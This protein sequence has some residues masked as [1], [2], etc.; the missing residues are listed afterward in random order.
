MRRILQLT[1]TLVVAFLLFHDI[2]SAESALIG[3]IRY[4]ID[5][6]NKT[7]AVTQPWYPDEDYI[8]TAIIPEKI[9]YKGEEYIVNALK[10]RAFYNC[11][12][13][14][15]VVVP[16]TIE[17]VGYQCFRYCEKLTDV[18]LPDNLP[19]LSESMFSECVSLEEI[20]LPSHITEIP[21]F[22]FSNCSGLKS[23]VIPEGVEKVCSQAFAYADRLI[24]ITLP[25]SLKEWDSN[26]AARY[27]TKVYI[28]NID[29]FAK[30]QCFEFLPRMY[31]L[32]KDNNEVKE[33]QLPI[34]V[35]DT[36]M[37]ENCGSIVSIALS[38]TV[39]S[40]SFSDANE[41]LEVISINSTIRNVDIGGLENLKTVNCY[42]P[43][44][45]A[46]SSGEGLWSH[47]DI[48]EWAVKDAILHVPVGTKSAYEASEEWSKFGTI[49][50]DLTG[51]S[52]IDDV[53]IDNEHCLEYYNLNGIKVNSEN[54]TPG[55][56]IIR[57]GIRTEKVLIR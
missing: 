52:G 33:V 34:G 15:K 23:I 51:D 40:C 45:P 30:I 20:V 31:Y 44:P 5:V 24:E 36:K 13:M 3:D 32:Y 22:C 26:F 2:A 47:V 38:N 37:F 54:I 57:N 46:S 18:T 39:E 9:T 56:Y 50:D 28:S 10:D 43:V 53:M 8:K 21:E 7:A 49:I 29:S 11:K 41:A 48:T 42:A 1:T 19:F 27:G 16:S 35:T 25:N 17:S 55:M 14:T 12:N 4:I 6:E